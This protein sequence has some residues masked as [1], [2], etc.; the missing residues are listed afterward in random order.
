MKR[1][2]LDGGHLHEHKHGPLMSAADVEAMLE[3]ALKELAAA[4][5]KLLTLL[6]REA[7]S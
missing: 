4:E 2:S 6:E 1:Y 3:R 7:G 5:D